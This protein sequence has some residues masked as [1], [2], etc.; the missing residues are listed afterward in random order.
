MLDLSLAKFFVLGLVALFIVG[1][2]RLPAAAA[3]LGHTARRARQ[4]IQT[5]SEQ[6]RREAGPELDQLRHPLAE[7]SEP[8]RELYKLRAALDPRRV[9]TDYLRNPGP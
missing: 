6:I 2:D 7:L 5:G 3:W 4:F 9:V 1:P 8:V